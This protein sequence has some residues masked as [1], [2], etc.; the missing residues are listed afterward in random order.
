V[1]VC[2]P[3]KIPRYKCRKPQKQGHKATRSTFLSLGQ[4]LLPILSFGAHCTPLRPSFYNF[5]PGSF[6]L[7]RTRA[8][9]LLLMTTTASLGSYKICERMILMFVCGNKLISQSTNLCIYLSV[10]SCCG[11]CSVHFTLCL[12]FLLLISFQNADVN[13][14]FRQYS[15]T[16]FL[17]NRSGVKPR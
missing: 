4:G 15:I 17:L 1:G 2:H 13:V 12:C 6:V 3:D 16:L 9:L 10:I 11:L 5:G 8:D 14:T 7:G